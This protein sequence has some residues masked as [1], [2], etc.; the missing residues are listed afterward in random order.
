MGKALVELVREDVKASKGLALTS[1]DIPR[2][3][4]WIK[5]I[6]VSKVQGNGCAFSYT[7]LFKDPAVKRQSFI[8]TNL[9]VCGPLVIK[10][11]ASLIVG[12]VDKYL[13]SLK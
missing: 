4:I 12:E 3:Q 2:I 10:D 7:V 5:T 6:D 8:L 9:G 1:D 11:A 13:H